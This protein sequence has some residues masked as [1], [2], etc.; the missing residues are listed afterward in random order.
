MALFAFLL[1]SCDKEPTITENPQSDYQPDR[2]DQFTDE[3]QIRIEGL[4][5]KAGDFVEFDQIR[6]KAPNWWANEIEQVYKASLNPN[7]RA[8]ALWGVTTEFDNDCD[9]GAQNC[10][11]LGQE[12]QGQKG[13]WIQVHSQNSG[14]PFGDMNY[15]RDD[16]NLT[17]YSGHHNLRY[18]N[19]NS[20]G[21][22]T[23]M[24]WYHIKCIG[25]GCG[26]GVYVPDVDGPIQVGDNNVINYFKSWNETLA[27]FQSPDENAIIYQYSTCATCDACD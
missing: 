24:F 19:Y 5:I 4:T 10:P 25:A 23:M 20:R 8:L 14:N 18:I 22:L 11:T 16:K 12:L 15:Y 26:A 13:S 27:P 9:C 3:N 21:L 1:T 2:Y 6:E 7:S 17:N